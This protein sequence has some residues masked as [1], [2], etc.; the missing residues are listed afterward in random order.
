MLSQEKKLKLKE[1]LQ[2]MK[3]SLE[4]EIARLEKPADF[5][6]FPGNEDEMDESAYAYNQKSAAASLRE[7]MADVSSALIKMEKGTYGKCQKCGRE[8]E[9]KVLDISPDSRLCQECNK[10]NVVKS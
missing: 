8:I 3:E 5:G 6:D 7:E 2:V 10:G 1:K 9:E 4:K